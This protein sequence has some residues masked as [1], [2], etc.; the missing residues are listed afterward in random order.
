M[1]Q[2]YGFRG[3]TY[4]DIWYFLKYLC[5]LQLINIINVELMDTTLGLTKNIIK[6]NKDKLAC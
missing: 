1:T 3:E 6:Q 2:P 4:T 5:K